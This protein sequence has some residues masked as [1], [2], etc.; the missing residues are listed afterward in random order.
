MT[1]AL[2]WACEPPAADSPKVSKKMQNQ[3][4]IKYLEG[5]GVKK[6]EKQALEWFKKSATELKYEVKRKDSGRSIGVDYGIPF[7]LLEVRNP[8]LDLERLRPGQKM[9]IPGHP[10][11]QFNL[12][13]M[14]EKDGDAVAKDIEKAA[15]WY[16]KSADAGFT[17]AE[18]MMGWLHRK[19]EGIPKDP[20][21]AVEWYRRAA[22]KGLEGALYNLGTL[23]AV[24]DDPV[25][26]DLVTAW[27]WFTLAKRRHGETARSELKRKANQ[28]I[29]DKK[30]NSDTWIKAAR[31]V[32]QRAGAATKGDELA[33]KTRLE[34]MPNGLNDTRVEYLRLR[35]DT[36]VNQEVNS[37]P[38]FADLPNLALSMKKEDKAEAE[39]QASLFEFKEDPWKKQ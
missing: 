25:K 14:Y 7:E 6:D 29:R 36:L 33:L 9:L 12:A 32:L 27:K 15:A 2:M 24:G 18:F 5:A 21:Q 8:G 30:T 10:G 17:Q 26:R 31:L 35:S 20:E 4:G 19:G 34:K 16:K 11:A 23:Y 39:R 38:S 22:V 13:A 1:L 37:D 3:Q 28:E